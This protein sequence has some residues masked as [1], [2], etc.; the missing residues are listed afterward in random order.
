LYQLFFWVLFKRVHFVSTSMG[1][2]KGP[3]WQSSLDH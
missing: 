2:I 3:H 1:E